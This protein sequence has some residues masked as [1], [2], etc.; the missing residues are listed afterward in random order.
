MLM[1]RQVETVGELGQA[2]AL[3]VDREICVVVDE[4]A[5]ARRQHRHRRRYDQIRACFGKVCVKAVG[6]LPK[7]PQRGYVLVGEH[8][9]AEGDAWTDPVIISLG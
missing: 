1:S 3:D 6:A 2:E 7:T 9:L 8:M 4:I 5:D